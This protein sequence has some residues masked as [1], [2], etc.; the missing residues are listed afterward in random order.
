MTPDTWM[1]SQK[2]T[3]T[4]I[5]R[6]AMKTLFKS[7]ILASTAILA[8]VGCQ[9]E[10]ASPEGNGTVHFVLHA[11]AP[12][13]KTGIDYDGAGKYSPYW[14]KGDEL[15]VI[16]TLPTTKGDLTPAAT[17]KNTKESGS[18][19]AFEGDVKLDDGKDVTFYS[20]YPASSAAKTYVTTDKTTKV[21][22]VTIGLDVPQAQSPAYD[23]TKGYSFD[24]KADILIAKPATCT[25]ASGKASN[26][27]DMY[28]AR[29]S[30]V[31]RIELD[32]A[33]T[34]KCYGEI[35]KS[36]EFKTSAGDI[37]GRIAVNPITGEYSKT[38]SLTGSTAI[39]ATYDTSKDGLVTIGKEN[40]NN[41]F[42]SVAPVTIKSGET[43]TVTIETV[44]AEGNEGHTIVKTFEPTNDIVFESSKPTVLKLTLTDDNIYSG[45]STTPASGETLSWKADE[46]GTDNAKTVNVALNYA[47][48]G[49]TVSH[50]SSTDWTVSDDGNGTITVYPN[51][52][53][54]STTAEK[55][56][57]VTVTHLDDA[58]ITS[59]VHLVQKVS[60]AAATETINFESEASA[61][62][63][64]TFTNMTSAQSGDITANG[65]GK[66]GTTGGGKSAS[67]TTKNAVAA[68]KSITF[69]I[70]KTSKNTTASSWKIQV[71]S[72]NSTWT[73]VNTTD[74]TTMEKGVWVGVTQDLS[75]YTNVYVRVSYSGSTAVRAIDD[76]ELT[77]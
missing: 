70:S 16:F 25:V 28:F 17:F 56:L 66:Y 39:T 67:I 20:F 77:L 34:V 36:L 22:T 44:T 72:D 65:G 9:K 38:N 62:T 61:Y 27:V 75:K 48:T 76:L 12:E 1:T 50:T 30:G 43:V 41:V 4:L 21:T 71:S 64:W 47:A 54:T 60:G 32:A 37:A 42:L 59:T 74:A 53:N 23:A 26:D 14:N 45:L 11:N 15:G 58:T 7:M 19:A 57:D 52:A 2:K 46:Y 55:T 13:T 68:P 3:L 31:L 51:A 33:S 18:T 49:Y 69:Y 40:E 73:D 8:A 5:N 24:P 63:F 35:V 10:S 29:L 6:A